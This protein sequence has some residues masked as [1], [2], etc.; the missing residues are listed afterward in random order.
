MLSLRIFVVSEIKDIIH[1]RQRS[2]NSPGG[3][4]SST[5]PLPGHLLVLFL[6]YLDTVIADLFRC[7]LE[8]D[9]DSFLWSMMVEMV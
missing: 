6:L 7:L 2:G 1:I 5:C 4:L 3:F 8:V 9:M